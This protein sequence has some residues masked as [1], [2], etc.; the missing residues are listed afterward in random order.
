VGVRLGDLGFRMRKV[1]DGISSKFKTEMAIE[2]Q[3]Q[4]F[5]VDCKIQAC[6][7]HPRLL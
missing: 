6:L 7:T 4:F 3:D 5:G 2:E 1:V